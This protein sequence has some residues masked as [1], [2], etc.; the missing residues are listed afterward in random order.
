MTGPTPPGLSRGAVGR[1]PGSEPVETRPT[2][3]SQPRVATYR[4][5]QD[6]SLAG[7]VADGM[8]TRLASA[9]SSAWWRSLDRWWRQPV[10]ATR[11]RMVLGGVLSAALIAWTATPRHQPAGLRAPLSVTPISTQHIATPPK[12]LR[13]GTRSG[14]SPVPH[15]KD[16]PHLVGIVGRLPGNA[17]A[18]IRARDGTHAVAVGGSYHDWR[19]VELSPTEAVFEREG[20]RTAVDLPSDD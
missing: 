1:K 14:T 17:L 4:R 7:V 2:T 16:G 15:Q 3:A 11:G 9:Q 5:S 12:S 18:L 20:E 6:P 19:L 10:S 8:R 13:R